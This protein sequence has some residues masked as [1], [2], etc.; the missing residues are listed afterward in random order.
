[1]LGIKFQ[2]LQTDYVVDLG[3]DVGKNALRFSFTS[4]TPFI[5]NTLRKI[6]GL[7]EASLFD[8]G[9]LTFTLKKDRDTALTRKKIKATIR[10]FLTEFRK[11]LLQA[12]LK[13]LLE[14]NICE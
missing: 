3:E 7:D 5:T 12:D 14:K 1:M 9:I 13:L 2:I 10:E 6:P 11:W 4:I 8:N